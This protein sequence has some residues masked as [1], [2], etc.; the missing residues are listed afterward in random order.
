MKLPLYSKMA[1]LVLFIVIV[2]T[3]LWGIDIGAS[4]LIVGADVTGFLGIRSANFQYH[5]GL[6]LVFITFL[7]QTF[8]I[9]SYFL[10]F[11]EK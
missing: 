9:L 6:A 7:I 10:K 2:M 1:I 8:W 11:K 3:G 4:A 5:L